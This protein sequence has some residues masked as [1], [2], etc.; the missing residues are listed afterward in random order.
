MCW[1]VPKH[2]SPGI[3]C[4]RIIYYILIYLEHYTILFVL[5][6]AKSREISLFHFGVRALAR[7]LEV[8]ENN[9]KKNV[10]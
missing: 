8:D 3:L 10:K 9:I 2:R 1:F 6:E 4:V 5:A 7:D